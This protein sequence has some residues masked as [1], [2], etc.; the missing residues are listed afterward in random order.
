MLPC[1]EVLHGTV[2]PAGAHTRAKALFTVCI[3]VRT[4]VQGAVYSMH[5]GA[6]TRAKTSLTACIF[7]ATFP[8]VETQP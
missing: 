3:W 2:E 6:H 8:H 7:A 1:I 5:L 4:H